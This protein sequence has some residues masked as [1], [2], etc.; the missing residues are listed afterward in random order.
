MATECGLTLLDGPFALVDQGYQQTYAWAN[1][2]LQV[3]YDALETLRTTP[4]PSLAFGTQL[5][6]NTGWW[7][8]VRPDKPDRPDLEFD[9][10]N[11]LIPPPPTVTLGDIAFTEPPTFDGVQPHLPT[12]IGPAP[13]DAV[14]PGAPPALV[15]PVK[16]DAPNI[17]IPDFPVLHDIVLPDVPTVV[18]PEFQGVRP[19]FSGMQT[20]INTFAFTPAQYTSALLEKTRARVSTMLDGATGLPLAI[21]QA[22][23]DRTFVQQDILESRAVQQA[24]E[25][26]SSLGHSEPQGPLTRR[27]AQTRQEGIN[28]RSAMNRDVHIKDQ[29]IAVEN[30]RFAVTQGI[31]VESLMI[32]EHYQF[33]QISLD[34]AKTAVQIE[35]DLFN[36]RRDLVALQLQAYQTDAQVHRDLIQ[37]ELVKLELYKAELEG[38]KLIGDLNQQM[39]SIYDTRVRAVLSQVEIYNA[40]VSAF[41]AEI[42]A[43]NSILEGHRVRILAYSER[44]K[45]W[46]IEWDAFKAQIE[47]DTARLRNYEISANVFG[48]RVQA[49]AGINTNKIAQQRLRIDEKQ[50]DLAAWEAQIKGLDAM[51]RAEVARVESLTRIYQADAGIYETEGRIEAIASDSKGRI[52]QMGLE[53]E[54]ERVLVSLENVRIKVNQMIENTKL[55]LQKQQAIAQVGAGLAQASMSAVNFS[56]GVSS[57][58][59]NSTSCDTNF[60]YTGEIATGG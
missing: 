54:K 41:K 38:L 31:A 44:V 2:S 56:A 16:P 42:E 23:R 43:N 33:A 18:I 7:D 27:V 14:A 19:D 57:N 4:I 49:W 30:L 25:E 48:T 15:A 52:F 11:N 40:Q 24:R 22:L 6:P 47:A 53:Q 45:A 9:P 50:L 46:A 17:V 60:N 58:Q 8:Y 3:T 21:A 37:A 28:A 29:E 59:S 13:L 12:R 39:V 51:I 26:Y 1:Q 32:Q 5:N 35:I 34:V 55:A 36:T 10:D 20:P